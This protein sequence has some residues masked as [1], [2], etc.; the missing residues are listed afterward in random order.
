MSLSITPL[1]NIIETYS[2]KVIDSKHKVFE[3]R[4]QVDLIEKLEQA[5]HR[6]LESTGRIDW[7]NDTDKGALLYQFRQ[8]EGIELPSQYKFTSKSEIENLI[9][10]IHKAK[11]F[12]VQLQQEL[13][14]NQVQIDSLSQRLQN[15]ILGIIQK[16]GE[17]LRSLWR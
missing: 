1:T 8:L 6:A 10:T 16:L 5:A 9:D 7:E 11:K 14:Q 13:E 4:I 17:M 15:E 3:H 2:T 12:H